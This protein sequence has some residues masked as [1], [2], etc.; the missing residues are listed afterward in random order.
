[1]IWNC[2]KKAFLN[3]L[4]ALL[5]SVLTDIGLQFC[6]VNITIILDTFHPYEFF[7]VHCS[8]NWVCQ[9]HHL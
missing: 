5:N 9:H 7:Q 6:D 4:A 8:R 1:M 3:L 2:D